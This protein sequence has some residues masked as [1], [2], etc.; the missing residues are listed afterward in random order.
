[1]LVRR[2]FA[3]LIC[4]LGLPLV[5]HA[6]D[7]ENQE[8]DWPCVQ[9]MVPE[10][11]AAVVWAGPPI[12]ELQENWWEIDDVNKLV[13]RLIAPD[14]D[15]DRADTEIAEFAAKLKPPR[16]DPMLT[17]LFAGVL[18]S[19]NNDRKKMFDG[20]WRYA[21]GQAERANR[22]GDDLDEIIRLESDTSAAAKSRL[23]MIQKEMEIKQRMFDERETFI[24]HLC[25]R[26]AVIEQKLGSLARAIAYYLD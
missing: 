3:T 19:L 1:M 11:S 2:L 24:Q 7:A 26:P 14:F 18:E 10:V 23:E 25:T 21:R 20:I 5:T 15:Q 13:Q 17:L 4:C 12:T 16:K 9:V 8:I 6:A 22:L